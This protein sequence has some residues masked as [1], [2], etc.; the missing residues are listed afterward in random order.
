MKFSEMIIPTL[1]E[2][3]ADAEIASH[4]LLLRGGFIRRLAS[5]SYN[6]LPLGLRVLKNIERIVRE[7]LER[8]GA[9]EILMPVVQPA[10]LWRGKRPLGR[11]GTRIA[12]SHRPPR[13]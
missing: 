7:E 8:A 5:G 3:P 12:A 2:A 9:Q 13:P 6:W 1:R 4:V 11:D 10:E